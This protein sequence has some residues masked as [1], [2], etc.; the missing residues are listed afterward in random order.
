MQRK[1][2]KTAQKITRGLHE[3]NSIINLARIK[4]KLAYFSASALLQYR[5]FVRG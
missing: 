5:A 1:I 2:L 4:Q 3:L